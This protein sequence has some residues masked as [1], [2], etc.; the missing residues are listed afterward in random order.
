MNN[1]LN[2]YINHFYHEDAVY[3]DHWYTGED[4]QN[5]YF[6]V[7]SSLAGITN[8]IIA[9][10]LDNSIEYIVSYFAILDT[11]NNVFPVFYHATEAEFNRYVTDTGVHAVF[12]SSEELLEGFSTIVKI[13]SKLFL[14]IRKES[15]PKNLESE[16]V[17][18]LTSGTTGK[19]SKIVIH[20]FRRLSF[21]AIEHARSV[22]LTS[23]DIGIIILPMNFGYCH[24][25]QFLTYIIKLNKMVISRIITSTY[26]IISLINKHG[27]TT[28][29]LTPYRLNLLKN[30]LQK[31]ENYSLKK[32]IF[33]G[34][35]CSKEVLNEIQKKS[36]YKIDFFQTYGQT[37]LGPRVTTKKITELTPLNNVGSVI[38]NNVEIKITPIEGQKVG[39]RIL[40]KSPFAM[41]KY[42]EDVIELDQNLFFDTGDIGYLKNNELYLLGRNSV[43]IKNKDIRFNPVEIE[44]YLKKHFP[45]FDF[46]LVVNHNILTL[47]V[48]A[49]CNDLI[50]R[51][52]LIKTLKKKFSSYKIPERVIYVKNFLRTS[53]GKIKRFH[54][55][56]AL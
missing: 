36:L 51:D 21:N 4:L 15:T 29:S 45:N 52:N 47:Y 13:N 39:G 40:V 9:I 27:V 55:S 17:L 50:D 1:Y 28:T 44:N 22:E 23:E 3:F 19:N 10:W 37:E 14:Q 31:E 2:N 34:A 5:L 30:A 41:R 38:N 8:K 6:K 35:T 20:D 11:T 54:Y 49:L 56:D 33:G 24:T 18:L 12:S 16:C 43:W 7:L 46:I 48:E 25:T 26:K 42:Y 32:I 53:S